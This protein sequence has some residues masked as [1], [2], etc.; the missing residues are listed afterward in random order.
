LTRVLHDLLNASAD[1]HPEKQAVFF[2]KAGLT[3]GAISR[4][5]RNL[6]GLLSAIG[7]KRGDRVAFFLEKRFEKVISVFGIS[8]AGGVMVPI[9]RLLQ[10]HQVAHII[11]NSGAKVLITTYSRVADIVDGL[12]QTHGLEK[13]IAIGDKGQRKNISSAAIEIIDWEQAINSNIPYKNVH[14]I[15]TDLAAILYTSGSTGQPKGVVLS[16]L[17]VVEGAKRVSEYLKISER[18]RLLS[19]L[20]FSFDYGLNQL[21]SAF[22][23]G[24]EIVL[25][26]Y[27]FPRDILGAVQNYE[28]TGLAAVATTWN[29]L[30]QR[31]WDGESMKSVRYIT[32][33][34]GAIPKNFVIEL[35]RRLPDAEIYLMYGLTEA[36]RSTYL[37]PKLVDEKPTSIGKAI[38]GEEIMVLDEKNKP[39]GAGQIGEL[40][41]RGI[42]VA[43]G[44]WN[45]PDLTAARFRPN[46]MQPPEVP[47]REI[48]VYSGDYVRVDGEGF[49]YFVGRKDEMIKTASN[50][51]SPTEVEEVIYSSGKIQDVIVMGIPHE[52]YGQ[53]IKAIMVARPDVIVGEDEIRE[54]CR[55]LLP[56]YMVP[57]EL[58]L[59]A[60]LPRNANG[61]LD[62][63][64]V[65]KEV[66]NA[67]ETKI[68]MGQADE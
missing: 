10:T 15:D 62:R 55:N 8:M 61:K 66:L 43:Q 32:N 37:E 44:Y 19:I 68:G 4:S 51:V 17:N 58:E 67:L 27:L 9:R 48:V 50:R 59:R 21:T 49:L 13:I 54:H 38:P 63:S 40:V 31:P 5:C 39:V 14:T 46:P 1:R 64:S 29:Q 33:T 53:V 23:N 56:P 18:D 45:E 25:L 24:A 36:F 57:S 2:K 6:G 41:H 20:T 52:I 28:I 16:H 11:Q 35:R 34:G 12:P 22:L 47:N 65:K 7:V 42:L 60:E 30:L 26:D 3:Y